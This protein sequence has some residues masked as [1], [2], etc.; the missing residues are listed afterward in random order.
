VSFDTILIRRTDATTGHINLKTLQ[1]YAN[2]INIL[3]SATNAT[4]SIESG[5][6]G[7]VIEFM[8]WNDLVA[9]TAIISK[10]ASNIRNNNVTDEHSIHTGN[11][12][13]A[14]NSLY[15]PLTQ[16]FNISDIQSLFIQSV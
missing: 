7:D 5:S 10:G 11:S 9:G 8:T 1:V 6:L 2:N 4:Q 12:N 16:S 3:P 13:T 15:I 14:Y